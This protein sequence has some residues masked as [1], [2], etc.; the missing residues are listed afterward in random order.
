MCHNTV[1]GA[2]GFKQRA[3]EI[4]TKQCICDESSVPV[5]SM[6]YRRWCWE[7][8]N[9]M[10]FRTNI[11]GRCFNN[12]QGFIRVPV[13]FT[14]TAQI[15][16]VTMNSHVLGITVCEI[17]HCITFS[18]F[19]GECTFFTLLVTGLSSA[20]VFHVV[21]GNQ[22]CWAKAIKAAR[23]HNRPT[24]IVHQNNVLLSLMHSR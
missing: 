20:H 8:N 14:H 19:Y 16:G 9:T 5:N 10:F 1:C 7:L 23:L 24:S 12:H 6:T 22:S 18:K 21:F 4:K 2:W 11:Y 3:L 15:Q 13:S 17:K